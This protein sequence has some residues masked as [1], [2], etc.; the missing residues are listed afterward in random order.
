MS[1]LA[2]TTEKYLHHICPFKIGQRVRVTPTY[3]YA[4]FFPDEYIVIGIR[5]EIELGDGTVSIKLA[6]DIHIAQGCGQV[7][8]FHCDDLMPACQKLEPLKA[9]LPANRP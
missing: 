5:W 3:R 9:P 6:K 8:K 4:A 2:S 7:G 1:T